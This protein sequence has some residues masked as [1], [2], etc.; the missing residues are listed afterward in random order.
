M[1]EDPPDGNAGSALA[2]LSICE[3]LLIALV[4]LKIL[5]PEDAV[6]VLTDATLPHGE[7]DP[8]ENSAARRQ[9]VALIGDIAA[10]LKAHDPSKF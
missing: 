6:G 2:A 1:S 10:S 8:P 7:D 5:S 9:A 3:S 4:D